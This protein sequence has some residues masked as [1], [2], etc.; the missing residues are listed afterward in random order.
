MAKTQVLGVYLNRE[1]TFG[2]FVEKL[3]GGQLFKFLPKL[4]GTYTFVVYAAGAATLYLYD[5]NYLS[6]SSYRDLSAVRRTIKVKFNE[7]PSKQIFNFTEDSSDIAKWLYKNEESLE[8]ATY[9][10]TLANAVT[11]RNNYKTLLEYPPRII[12][13][14]MQGLGFDL[15]PTDKMNITRTRGDN[16]G[17]TF[18]GVLFR[19]LEVTKRMGNNTTK[20]KAQLDTQ[21]YV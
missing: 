2:Q 3:E 21:T 8:V 20:I 12:E 16:T 1:I 17:G 9:L 13:F 19:V 14:E 11:L 15:I 4:D 18:D 6:F 7:N 5:E 10:Y